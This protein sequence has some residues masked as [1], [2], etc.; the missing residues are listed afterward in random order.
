MILA[1]GTPPSASPT[2]A[3]ESAVYRNFSF[4]TRDCAMLGIHLR[5]KFPT[6]ILTYFPNMPTV[7][8]SGTMIGSKVLMIP[9]ARPERSFCSTSS[10]PDGISIIRMVTSGLHLTISRRKLK[11]RMPSSSHREPLSRTCLRRFPFLWDIRLSINTFRGSPRLSLN[12][13]GSW[14]PLFNLL[15]RLRELGTVKQDFREFLLSASK[16]AR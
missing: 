7:R 14:D 16:P 5:G 6:K 3:S 15:G 9:V 13:D 10:M 1:T 12:S 2:L 8:L 4:M 11:K